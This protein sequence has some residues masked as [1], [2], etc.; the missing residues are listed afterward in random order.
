MIRQIRGGFNMKTWIKKHFALTD[1]GASDIVKAIISS[2]LLCVANFLPAMLLL[3]FIDELV[4][5]NVKSHSL[6]L[7]ISLIV[8][9]IIYV[10]LNVNYDDLYNTTY[11]E[12]ANLRIDIANRLSQLPLSY[13]S[14]HDLSDL[15]Q[16]IM[17]DVAAI[18][19]AMSHSI[20]RV[21]AIM[22]FFPIIALCLIIGNIKLGLAV[23]LPIVIGYLLVLLSK[24]LQI[25]EYK[26][27]YLKLRDNSESFQEAIENSQEIRSYGLSNKINKDLYKKMDE[28]EKIHIKSEMSSAIPLLFSNIVMQMSLALVLI[29]GMKLLI[30]NEID[31]LYL[32]AYILSAMKIKELVEGA[33]ENITEVYYLDAMIARINEIRQTSVQ[34]GEDIDIQSYD[35]TLEDVHFSYNSDTPVLKGVSFVAKQN[36]VT[37]LVGLS[38]CGKT[39]ILRLISRLYDYDSGKIIIDGKEIK[40]ISTDSLFENIAIVFQ[41][42]TL[43]NASIMENIRIGNKKASD[44]QVIAAAKAAMI[45]EYIEQLPGGYDTVLGENGATLSGGQRQRLSIARAILKNSPIIIFDEATSFTDLENEHKIQLALETLLKGKTTIMIAHR[46]HTIVEADQICVFE[47]GRLKEKGTHS[48][49]LQQDERYKKMWDIYCKRGDFK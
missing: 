5:N 17:D 22:F 33:T 32:F 15:S 4:L 8:L 6:Y 1:K 27:Y 31:L 35:I 21:F 37:A 2:F 26:K 10:L 36:E 12:S 38:G 14:K 11:K 23:V 46:L 30:N 9:V 42:V 47:N 41:D 16:T 3:L 34:S 28:S 25:R 39:S 19:H 24:K 18:E 40:N 29:V 48:T 20:P 44:E 13:F 45:H 43:F 7:I 49:L